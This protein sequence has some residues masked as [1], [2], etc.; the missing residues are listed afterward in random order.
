MSRTAWID[1][2]GTPGT[3]FLV[4]G[5][6]MSC[7][8]G[9]RRDDD[10]FDSARLRFAANLMVRTCSHLKLEGP[11][12]VQPSRDGNHPLIHCAVKEPGDYAR[13]VDVTGASG[14]EPLQWRGR[15]YFQLDEAHHEALLAI[16]GPPDGRGAGRRARV[17]AAREAEDQSH[18]RWGQD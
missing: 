14:I 15:G 17:A 6:L 2:A 3:A 7:F 8:A 16:A 12:A 9:G 11:F 4:V 18:Y 1:L 13:L 5:E 10:P